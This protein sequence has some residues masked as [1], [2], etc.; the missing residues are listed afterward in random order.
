MI[1]IL[2]D[3][4]GYFIGTNTYLTPEDDIQLPHFFVEELPP[5][6]LNIPANY[7]VKINSDTHE[8]TYEVLPVESRAG[9]AV[10]L[11]AE[12]LLLKAQNQA[13]SDRAEFIEDII[14]EMAIKIY[15]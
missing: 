6:L 5:E 14:A 13:L 10:S 4:F 3:E 7:L 1:A 15:Q 9:S 8:I 12:S 2:Y 11:A